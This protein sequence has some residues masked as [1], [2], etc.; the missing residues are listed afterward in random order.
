M[1]VDS[2]RDYVGQTVGRVGI[3]RSR[4]PRLATLLLARRTDN[5]CFGLL[6]SAGAPSQKHIRDMT[7]H[8][9]K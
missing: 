7:D 4:Y 2:A 9:R 5:Y 1:G 3:V 6:F 8:M